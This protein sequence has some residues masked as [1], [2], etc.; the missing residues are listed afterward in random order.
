MYS[1]SQ[2]NKSERKHGRKQT[3]ES[4]AEYSAVAAEGVAS[5][6]TVRVGSTGKPGAAADEENAPISIQALCGTGEGV[7]VV[8][9]GL[10]F[11]TST[12]HTG[13]RVMT[14]I[15]IG[16]CRARKHL[17]RTGSKMFLLMF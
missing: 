7:E 1:T 5:V 15:S 12:E 13:V 8:T 17:R 6:R 10:L 16:W 2:R 11:F 3:G 9:G 4:H 14:P